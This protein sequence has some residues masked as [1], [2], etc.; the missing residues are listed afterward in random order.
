MAQS[1]KSKD[2]VGMKSWSKAA[3]QKEK[4][5]DSVETTPKEPLSKKQ[6]ISK[7]AFKKVHSLKAEAPR[8]KKISL[9]RLKQNYWPDSD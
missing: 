3:T 7:Q 1:K 2:S 6:K 9:Y 5:K 4:P 8:K